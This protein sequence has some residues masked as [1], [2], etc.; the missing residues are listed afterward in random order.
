MSARFGVR[1]Y[2]LTAMM[3]LAVVSVVVTGLL[4]RAG[5]A[6]ELAENHTKLSAALEAC[7]LRAAI[8]AGLVAGALALLIA[9]PMALRLAGPLR[10]LNELAGEVAHGRIADSP[11]AVGGAREI[12]ELGATLEDLGATLRHQE[13]LRGAT[14]ADVSHELRGALSGMIG[15]LEAVQDGLIDRDVGLRRLAIDARRLGAIIDDVPRLADAQRPGLL[16]RKHAV[17]LAAVVRDRVAAHAHR[18]A[19]ASIELEEAVEPAWVD[20]DRER[21]AQVVDNLLS[22]ALRYTDPG[23]RVLVS[24]TQTER[25]SVIEVAD[26]G[27]GIAEAHLAYVFDRFWRAPSARYRATGGSGVGLAL[28]RDLVLAHHGNVEVLSRLGSGSRFRVHL[29]LDSDGQTDEPLQGGPDIDAGSAGPVTLKLNGD[30]DPANS[31]RVL[32]QLLEHIRATRADL[33]LDLTNV[34]YFDS[35]GVTVL[36]AANAELRSRS[37]RMVIVGAPPRV[38]R[39]LR[40]A[41]LG[42]DRPSERSGAGSRRAGDVA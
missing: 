10:R 16:V 42:P 12:T 36:A 37:R 21:L 35:A 20:G 14:A 15:R 19:V 17:D 29:P 27:V 18:F 11:T 30:I 13:E 8:E 38:G 41:G 7:I 2:L 4:T 9:L 32:C 22:N 34:S 5:I 40:L 39:L 25:E 28:V 33:V 31:Q 23:G 24:L 26:S 3:A 1:S 6:A